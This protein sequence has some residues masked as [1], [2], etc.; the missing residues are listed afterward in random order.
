VITIQRVRIRWTAATRGAPSADARRGLDTPV[1]LLGV[2]P[3]GEVVVQDVLADET[4][5]Y[6]LSHKVFGGGLGRARDVGLWLE[7]QRRPSR[8]RS[9]VVARR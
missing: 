4:A 2:M 3:D 1:R 8:Y 5:G 9:S 6:K 7:M